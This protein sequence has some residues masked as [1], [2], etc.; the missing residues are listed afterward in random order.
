MFVTFDG[1]GDVNAAYERPQPQMAGCVEIP[2]SD[3]R[4]LAFNSKTTAI[5]SNVQILAQ[6]QSLEAQQQRA[7]RQIALGNGSVP[8]LIPQDGTATPMQHVQSIEDQITTLRSQ[9]TPI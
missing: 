7:L 6:I 2:N 9:I 4:L 5:A 1:N 3:P 8:Y